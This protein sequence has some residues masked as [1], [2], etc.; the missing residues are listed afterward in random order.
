LQTKHESYVIAEDRNKLSEEL[1]N[2]FK[3]ALSRN[4]EK[5]RQLL[6]RGVV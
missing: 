2:D 3:P 5:L 6:N 4:F 1:R